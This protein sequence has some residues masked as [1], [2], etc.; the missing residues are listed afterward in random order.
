MNGNMRGKHKGDM[1]MH[2]ALGAPRGGISL[3]RAVLREGQGLL[4]AFRQTW[5]ASF[6]GDGDGDSHYIN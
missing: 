3:L 4:H 2:G 5:A 1:P 6:Q